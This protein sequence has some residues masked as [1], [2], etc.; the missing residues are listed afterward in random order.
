MNEYPLASS[1]SVTFR[2]LNGMPAL[3]ARADIEAADPRYIVST[4][5]RDAL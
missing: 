2:E 4:I 1:T 5:D 3:P